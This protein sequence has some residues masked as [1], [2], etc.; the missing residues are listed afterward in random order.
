MLCCKF[1]GKDSFKQLK[2][3]E[4]QCKENPNRTS[5]AGHVGKNHYTYGA[6]CSDKTRKKISEY[7]KTRVLSAKT[8]DKISVSR[9]KFLDE[10]PHM[11]PYVL[12]HSSK[13]SYPEQ[14]FRDCFRGIELDIEYKISRYSLD[15]ANTKRKVYFEVDGE[16][17]YTDRKIVLSDLKRTK[18]LQDLGWTG[19]RCRWSEFQKLNEVE[20]K[21]YVQKIIGLVA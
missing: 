18:F 3:H 2:T 16:Q 8:R 5:A 10:N 21:E 9:I 17:H 7:A 14:Y 19:Y 6:E 11:V 12:N 15:F 13:I 20:C 4:R 1:C